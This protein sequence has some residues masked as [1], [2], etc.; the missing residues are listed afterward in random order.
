M[1]KRYLLAGIGVVFF[2]V[3]S[4]FA[5]TEI[6]LKDSTSASGFSVKDSTG[7]TIMRAVGSGNVGIGTT[8]PIHPLHMGSGTHVTAAGVWTNAS[9]REYKDN[10]RD[11]TVNEA[12]A[13]LAALRP[14]RFN[15]K[16]DKDDEYVGFIAEDVPELVATK[17]R[18]GLAPMDITAVL[19]KVVQEQQRTL[20]EAT[21]TI[22]AL[23]AKVNALENKI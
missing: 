3:S 20:Q 11:L 23:S 7:N 8:N 6:I 12:M 17:D 4:V 16:V 15:Y 13:T 5:E 1:V 10:I 14:S 22:S 9:S 19:T 18:K 21:E 2:C